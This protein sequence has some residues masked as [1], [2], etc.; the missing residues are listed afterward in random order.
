MEGLNF[1]HRNTLESSIS[2]LDAK[3]LCYISVTI[4]KI[5]CRRHLL[6]LKYPFSVSGAPGTGSRSCRNVSAV[7]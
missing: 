5:L 4:P 6:F 2:I 7:E 1:G 3:N